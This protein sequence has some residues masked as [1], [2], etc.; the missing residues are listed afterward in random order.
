MRGILAC[1]LAMIVT[2][3]LPAA[4]R[5]NVV[6]VLADDLGISDL[7]CYGN[8]FHETPNIDK[9]A[10]DGI[11]LTNAYS[12][13][14][15]CSPTRAA[16]MTGQY[17]ARLHITDWIA[18]HVKP[19]AKLSVPDWTMRLD[20]TIYTMPRAFKEAG[21]V[22][23]SMGKWHL[24]GPDAYPEKHGFDLNIAGTDKGQPPSYF[25]P[26]KIATLKDGPAG[27]LITDRLA[28]EACRWIEA[29]REKPFFLYL[30]QFA[31]HTPLQ[32]KKEVVEKYRRKMATMDQTRAGVMNP[33][34]AALLEGLDDS[35]GTIRKKLDELKLTDNT[36]F[37]FTSDNGGLLGNAKNPITSNPPYRAGKGSAYEGGVRVPLIVSYPASLKSK[38]GTNDQ[39]FITMDLFPTLASFC[40]LTSVKS[41]RLDGKDKRNELLGLER[42]KDYLY[43]HYPHYHPGG[44]TPYSAVLSP[45]RYRLIAFFEDDHVELYN[46][47]ADVGEKTDLAATMPDKAK[48]LRDNLHAWR[49]SVGAQ[50]PT[51]NPKYDPAKK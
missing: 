10:R 18:G 11:R 3:A 30:P 33:T 20:P 43:W 32:G 22:T 13:C 14:T 19:F 50:L 28:S 16:L 34:Y 45:D 6:L 37:I 36:I 48:E 39:S 41:H 24:G 2:Q 7:G 31:V 44:A 27:E 25:S 26:Y 51:K 49:K 15:V 29:N 8:T 35:V 5:P 46:L 40:G 17:P 42:S 23:A 47:K 21:Y 12:A 38:T 9:L 1:F 4:D